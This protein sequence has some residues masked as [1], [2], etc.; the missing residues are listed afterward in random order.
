VANGE[1]GKLFAL[2]AFNSCLE[3]IR[4]P[5]ARRGGRCRGF[6]AVP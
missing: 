2:F 4:A 3:A 1:Q 5:G 6:A